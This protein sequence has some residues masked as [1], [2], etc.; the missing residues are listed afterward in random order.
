VEQIGYPW[1]QPFVWVAFSV[2]WHPEV[3]FYNGFD[4]LIFWLAMGGAWRRWRE[5][6][7]VLVWIATSMIALLL[8][9]TKW[10]Q[11]ALVVVPA[12]CLAAA[13]TAAW[14]YHW[15]AEQETYWDWLREMVPRPP[16][17]FW[18]IAI[19]FVVALTAG[20]LTTRIE[21]MREQRKWSHFNAA[22]TPLPGNTVYDIA[23]ASGGRLILGT[24]AGAAIWSPPQ[25]AVGP[26]FWQVF[27]PAN[28]GLPGNDVLAV[29][30]DPSGAFWFGTNAGLA[31]YAG[32]AW[33]TFRARDIGL[34][35]DYVHALA[36][37]DDG[38]LWVGTDAGAA[39]FDGQNWTAF[40]P[41]SGLSDSLVLSIAVEPGS[42][43]VW[44]GAG[45]GLSRLDAATGEWTRYT[46]QNSPLGMGGVA[47]V[48]VDTAGRVWAATLGGGVGLWDG[49][50]WRAYNVSNAAIASNTVQEVF[51]DSTGT[52]WVGTSW[53][54]EFGGALVSL[55]AN[56]WKQYTPARSGFSGAETLAIAQDAL[57][58]IW[59]GTWSA[60]VDVYQP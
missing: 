46:S 58:R 57:G 35:T 38:R 17:A 42:G 19:F 9:P 53:P 60:G 1:Y 34:Q 56:G 8:W 22:N 50:N 36:A 37:G 23:A 54:T 33:T 16:R 25:D 45:T 39:V 30:Q 28:S 12:L 7:W 2:P 5:R 20:Y 21:T 49:Q 10:P 43:E 26:D 52:L 27:M 41:D 31:R 47:D 24:S 40:P 11:Y 32:G 29:A 18:Y 3:F 48:M 51:E 13:P 15:I 4:G 59:I 55:D 14:L 6:P 44:F